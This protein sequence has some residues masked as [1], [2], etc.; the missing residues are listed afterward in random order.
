M[1]KPDKDLNQGLTII[2]RNGRITDDDYGQI[3]AML[4]IAFAIDKLQSNGPSLQFKSIIEELQGLYGFSF[5][6]T[7]QGAK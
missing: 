3:L 5:V 6:E 2:K 7:N 4:A 1:L